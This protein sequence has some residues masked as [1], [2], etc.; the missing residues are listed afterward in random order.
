[1][2]LFLLFLLSFQL[3]LCK[4]K[5]VNSNNKSGRRLQDTDVYCRLKIFLDFTNF[6]LKFPNDKI[7]EDGKITLR[8]S[9]N[10]MKTYAERMFS[11]ITDIGESFEDIEDQNREDWGLDVWEEEKF[12]SIEFGEDN[13]NYYIAFRFSSDKLINYL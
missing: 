13:Y 3:I 6:E 12:N 4:K 7:G 5:N 10:N 8:T 11:I 2:K 1:M 9:I